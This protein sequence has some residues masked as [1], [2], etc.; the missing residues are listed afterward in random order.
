MAD[1]FNDAM[2]KTITIAYGT[3]IAKRITRKGWITCISILI[4]FIKINFSCPVI[5]VRYTDPR[6]VIIMFIKRAKSIIV[7]SFNS[8]WE[9]ELL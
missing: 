4:P 7:P 8:S 1:A 6:T 5:M 9:K 2:T 3:C